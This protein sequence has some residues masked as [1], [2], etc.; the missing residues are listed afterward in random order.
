M[1]RPMPGR[2]ASILITRRGSAGTAGLVVTRLAIIASSQVRPGGELPASDKQV[3]IAWVHAGKLRRS[4]LLAF[5]KP[6]VRAD[7][8]RWGWAGDA[9]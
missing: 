9:G 2:V 6:W 4:W 1:T 7:E 5:G 3:P 8:V